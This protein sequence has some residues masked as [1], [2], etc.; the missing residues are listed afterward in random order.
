MSSLIARESATGRAGA[1]M[2]PSH[3]RLAALHG[4]L[5][6]RHHRIHNGLAADPAAEALWMPPVVDVGALLDP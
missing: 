6:G 4:H 2:A 3:S 1:M 5:Q